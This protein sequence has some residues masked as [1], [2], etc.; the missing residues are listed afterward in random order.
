MVVLIAATEI[1]VQRKADRLTT[2][3]RAAWTYPT[4]SIPL[5]SRAQVLALG[6]SLIKYGVSPKVLER[7]LGIRAFNLAVPG[8][9]AFGSYQILRHILDSGAKP[10]IIFVD[11]ET[12][13]ADPCKHVEYWP[14]IASMAETFEL[15]WTAGDPSFLG[16]TT[17]SQLLPSY[18][19]RFEVRDWLVAELQDRPSSLRSR[20]HLPLFRRNW[21]Q[22]LGAELAMPYASELGRESDQRVS[23]V[24]RERHDRQPSPVQPL[25]ACYS[26][27]FVELAQSHGI[28][29]FWLIPPVHPEVQERR[30]RQGW[31]HET[32]TFLQK[33]SARY[34]NL[35]VVDGRRAGYGP[36]LFRDLVHLDADGA[37]AFTS[38]LADLVGAQFE[39][40]RSDPGQRWIELKPLRAGEA[41]RLAGEHNAEVEDLNES[42][43]A[44]KAFETRIR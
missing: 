43:A 15:A 27:R 12:L 13:A 36:E 34:P 9:E 25:N 38:R 22:N 7:R 35:T 6:D 24:Q 31:D 26:A 32:V 23:Q 2:L 37:I 21:N 41:A 29:V 14:E 17:C 39:P 28:A 33:L 42:M 16:M 19:L 3:D 10:K 11:G 5:A 40:G 18:R 44:F 8:G 1:A 30:D 20:T 4:R